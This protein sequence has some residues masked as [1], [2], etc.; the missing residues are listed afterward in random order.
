MRSAS[1]SG[2]AR[3]RPAASLSAASPAATC[4]S[5][6]APVSASIRR[7]PLAVAASLDEL[8]RADVAGAR[9]VRAA[10]QLQRIGL[11]ARAE[12]AAGAQAHRDDAHLV[13]VL[14]AEQRAGALTLGGVRRHDPGLDRRVLADVG[15]DLGLDRRDFGGRHR[16]GVREVNDARGD[17]GGGGRG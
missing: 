2:R 17:G 6:A 12:P 15:V 5:A 10:A 13:A 14:L 8:E 3:S 9:D 11:A 4:A 7:T 1:S 16:L